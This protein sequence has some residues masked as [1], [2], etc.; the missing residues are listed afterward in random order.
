MTPYSPF[1]H[2]VTAKIIE[3]IN[4]DD[5]IKGYKNVYKLDPAYLFK[6]SQ[7][8]YLCQCPITDLLFYFPF[9][10]DGD[11]SFYERISKGDWYYAENRWEHT[12]AI[13]FIKDG[14]TV[15]EI[16]SG[17]GSF[18]K[19]L[20]SKKK[21]TYTGLELNTAAIERAEQNSIYLKNELLSEHV[22][23]NELKYDVVCSFQVYEHISNIDSVFSDSVKSLKAGGLLIVS[24]PNND[25]ACIR[26]NKHESR[27]LNM[28]PHHTNLFTSGSL[29]KIALHYD[30]KLMDTISEPI[31]DNLI[32]SYLYN[33]FYKLFLNS[34][35]LVRVA[36]K[37]KLYLP[38]VA[39][40]KKYRHKIKGHTIIAVYQK[41]PL[42]T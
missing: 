7:F 11:S 31:Q 30:L 40:V 39:L 24:V 19:Q 10:L 3:K 20:I 36:W 18:L 28:P 16:G 4:A 41:S 34:N 27:F 25:L 2:T 8:I 42:S 38:A 17:A 29:K 5:I 33:R 13:D 26:Y 23:K 14:D 1:D 6:N 21:I 12:K 32:H 22:K 9:Q 37:L 15:L 35:F